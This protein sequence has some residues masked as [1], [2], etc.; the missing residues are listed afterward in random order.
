[1]QALRRS[2]LFVVIS[3]ALLA[4]S[5]DKHAAEESAGKQA[6]EMLI[7]P[8]APPSEPP[9]TVAGSA[10]TAGPADVEGGVNRNGSQLAYEHRVRVRLAAERVAGNLAQARE[11]CTA[12]KFGPCDLLGEQLDAG[13]LPTGVLRMRAAPVAIAPLVKLAADGGEVAE[14]N[15]SAEDLAEAVRDNGLRRRRLELQHAKLSEIM[16]RR[17]AK[18]EDLVALSD[19]LAQI[20]AE[21]QSVEQESAQQ[22]RRIRTN[23]LDIHF[24]SQVVG[25]AVEPTSRTIVALRQLTTIWD[26]TIAVLI[27]VVA[28][29][30]LPFALLVGAL[31]W[32]FVALRRR[33]RQ[34]RLA[35]QAD[36]SA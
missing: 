10:G 35:P 7:A 30:L 28:G 20:E 27:T 5:C 34:P 24:E 25:V 3:F 12:Q 4:A 9:R 29:A 6:P 14:R 8:S 33:R 21:L 16:Q 23:L 32:A 36:A 11:A 13:D 31:A 17:D 1:M 2:A 15:T 18:I 22:Q 19:R 26:Q